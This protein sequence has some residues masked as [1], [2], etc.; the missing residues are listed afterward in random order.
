MRDSRHYHA[1]VDTVDLEKLSRD[2]PIVRLVNGMLLVALK[3]HAQQGIFKLA[4][5][6]HLTLEFVSGGE[7]REEMRPP[8]KLFDAILRR[9]ATM[10][11]LEANPKPSETLGMT[12]LLLGPERRQP[13]AFELRG[14][15][16]ERSAHFWPLTA[17]ELQAWLEKALATASQADARGRVDQ[18]RVGCRMQLMGS[19]VHTDRRPEEARAWYARALEAKLKGDVSGQ[20]DH[21]SVAET[22]WLLGHCAWEDA[23]YSEAQAWYEKGS[24]E[25]E[26][27]QSENTAKLSLGQHMV[28]RCLFEQKQ[29]QAAQRWFERAAASAEGG[30][31]EGRVDHCSIGLSLECVGECLVELQQHQSAAA[32]FA[33]AAEAKGQ[34]DADGWI[35]HDGL[36]RTEHCAGDCYWTLKQYEPAREW[37]ERAVKSKSH[38]DWNEDVDH[39][40]LALS[41]R[42]VSAC[43]SELGRPG[44]AGIWLERAQSAEAQ[45]EPE[46]PTIAF[47]ETE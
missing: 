23:N 22:M 29:F 34:G 14:Q 15:G 40:S 31:A 45:H 17:A 5:Q 32:W 37:F 25:F 36:G 43:L 13:F 4:P 26:L 7:T 39:S 16:L 35:D 20:L 8:R 3:K 30:D 24:S 18:H 12:V 33:R 44:E 1:A 46:P 10:F 9:F 28:G 2:R 11:G 38:G 47:D 21:V 27:G 19:W 6:G 42:G 41:L